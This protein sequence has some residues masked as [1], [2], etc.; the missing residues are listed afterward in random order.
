V[1][2]LRGADGD[3]APTNLL[4]GKVN[5]KEAGLKPGIRPS[6]EAIKKR[7]GKSLPVDHKPAGGQRI[8]LIPASPH[9]IDLRQPE[10][11]KIQLYLR[12]DEKYHWYEDVNGYTVVE[13]LGPFVYA[14]LNAK[15]ALVPT[16]LEVGKVKPAEHGL[17]KRI[18]PK[19]RA[20]D[21]RPMKARPR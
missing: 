6:S 10:G 20:P 7:R 8:S 13:V 11:S 14:V 19:Q 16:E 1:Y 9:A 12:G 4:V 21:G 18:L 15:G 3:L 2:A 5:P 17:E